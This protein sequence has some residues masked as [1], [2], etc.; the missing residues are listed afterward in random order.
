M[1]LDKSTCIKFYKR[2]DIQEAIINHAKN[3]EIGMRYHDFFGKRPDILN[4]PKEILELSLRNLTSFHCSEEIWSNPLQLSP[5]LK[6]QDLNELRIGWDLVLDIDCPD[7][8][9]SKLTAHLF[10]KALQDNQVKSISCK[11]SGNK[12][13]HIGVPFEAFPPEIGSQKTK[14]LFPEG[15][16]KIAQ[17]LLDYISK[18]Y[19]KINSGTITFEQNFSYSLPQLKEKFGDKE[20]LQNKCSNCKKKIKIKQKNSE[21]FSHEFICTKCEKKSQTD[22]EFLK[23]DKCNILMEKIETAKT[24]CPCGSNSYTANFKPS[25]IIEVDTILISSRHLYR[26]PYSL[27]EKSGLVSLPI[28]P[29]QILHFSR[30]QAHPEII[31]S[32]SIIFLDR[33]ILQE[34][35]RHLLMQAWDFKTQ[36]DIQEQSTKKEKQEK[37]YDEF[38]LTAAIP[39]EFFPPCIKKT[40]YG[41]EDGKKRAIFILTNFLGKAGWNKIEIE[42]F[43]EEWNKK[44]PAPLREVYLKGQLHNLAVGERLPPNCDNEGYYKGLNL[45]H[46][47]TFCP[48]IKNPAN[49]AILKWKIHLEQEEENKPKRKKKSKEDKINGD[50]QLLAS[51]TTKET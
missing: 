22:K 16:Q 8:E 9:F 10:I 41:L 32:P 45:C 4:Y 20:F 40:S 34:N 33:H 44:N 35:A 29:S 26:M 12:G 38:D 49:Y 17:Y 31:A 37:K 28:E 14:Y 7:W 13:F 30:E 48:K 2:K 11:F 25:S 24:V 39:A 50:K 21:E 18:N 47:D 27:H 19:I 1:P 42:Q 43:L 46:P 15:P 5:E 36:L 23:C 6:K 3:K 51:N